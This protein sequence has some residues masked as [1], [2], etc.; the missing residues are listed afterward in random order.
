MFVRRLGE[1]HELAIV[2]KENTEVVSFGDTYTVVDPVEM[3]REG[4]AFLAPVGNQLYSFGDGDG[5][6]V[7][8]GKGTGNG[9]VFPDEELY[10]YEWAKFPN[11]KFFVQGPKKTIY[12]SGNPNKPL[13]VYISEPASITNPRKD[14]PYSTEEHVI[15]ASSGRL[16]VVDIIGSN[17]DYITAL[18]SRGNQVVVH[19]NKGCHLLYAPTSD[20][21]ETGYRVEQAPAT[22]FSAAV[23]SQVV[24][25]ETGSM[26]FWLGH[27]GQIYKDESASR[28]AE[29]VKNYADPAQVSWKSKS[30]W[31]KELH[32]DL[33]ESFAAYDRQSGMYW[34]YVLAPEYLKYIENNVPSL[35]T[36]LNAKPSIPG[37]VTDLSTLASPFLV[38]ALDA[39]PELPGVVSGVDAT[40][41]IPGLVTGLDGISPPFLVTALDAQPEL[42][43]YI[44]NLE[45]L[46]QPSLVTNLNATPALPGLVTS[47][48]VLA[49]IPGLVSNLDATPQI[50]GLV[51]SLTAEKD[52]VLPG[53]VGSLDATPEIPGLV[54]SLDATAEI[55]GLVSNLDA[56]PELP[57][58]VSSLTAE[59]PQ[60][61]PAPDNL[62]VILP[63][64]LPPSTSAQPNWDP[65]SNA[66]GYRI[67]VDAD[68]GGTLFSSPDIDLTPDS[69][70]LNIDYLDSLQRYAFRV[71]ALGDGDSFSDSDWSGVV[72]YT[73]LD[74]IPGL[75]SDLDATPELP[76][77]AG[78]LDATPEL[79]GL[80]SDLKIPQVL[81]SPWLSVGNSDDEPNAISYG[82]GFDRVDKTDVNPGID[83]TDYDTRIQASKFVD[84]SNLLMDSIDFSSSIFGDAITADTQY[85]FR[86]RYENS[87]EGHT[88]SDWNVVNYFKPLT[89]L[90]TPENLTVSFN[91]NMGDTDIS[92]EFTAR[93]D[94]V[95]NATNY[96]SQASLN[97]NMS[98]PTEISGDSNI[99][100][101][102]GRTA[103]VTYYVRFKAQAGA[104]YEDSDWTDIVSYTTGAAGRLAMPESITTV[105]PAGYDSN[106]EALAMWSPVEGARGYQFLVNDD[107]GG[108]RESD[109]PP[110]QFKLINMA[111]PPETT[112]FDLRDVTGDPN[113]YKYSLLP[114]EDYYLWVRALATPI[115]DEANSNM[116]HSY[117]L[118]P[119]NHRT[120]NTSALQQPGLVTNLSAEAEDT[121]LSCPVA[122]NFYWSWDG[123]KLVD[124]D[125]ADFDLNDTLFYTYVSYHKHAGTPWNGVHNG[126]GPF[127]NTLETAQSYVGTG[128]DDPNV[129]WG[130]N[131]TQKPWN[132]GKS[133]SWNHSLTGGPVYQMWQALRPGARDSE[134]MRKYYADFTGQGVPGNWNRN[135]KMRLERIGG[136]MK[137]VWSLGDVNLMTFNKVDNSD[138]C[139]MTG[140][141]VEQGEARYWIYVG[142]NPRSRGAD[143]MFADHSNG[144]EFELYT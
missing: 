94:E 26:S 53:L 98:D 79:P 105:I 107:S 68:N 87:T 75:V 31:E 136:V 22:N 14:S 124:N 125:G 103:G 18:S 15:D 25:G 138:P 44:T 82:Y 143:R 110:G 37:L 38:T 101:Y 42:P 28:G 9:G 20:Q 32:Y 1:V 141:Y 52:L 17:A 135:Y 81:N 2:S 85:Y 23:S 39:T 12:A 129:F 144:Q 13:R 16:S 118:G 72:Y 19:T 134:G 92:S 142:L 77:L 88:N 119:L 61:L 64:F 60:Q 86:V 73:T 51:S 59:P 113:D 27:D 33:S 80:V 104:G 62:R 121:G 34:I 128:V 133:V 71:K 10:S 78:N 65:V 126:G 108:D 139:Q 83:P 132:G 5:E 89:K 63:V 106:T 7:F 100:R 46:V 24:A 41:S 49:E 40:P 130:T 115:G 55:S 45:I 96:V 95:E 111:L 102:V 127:P 97:F 109:D 116:Q 11:C 6:A 29:D 137:L 21:A 70:L 50:P 76:G 93:V 54:N 140:K 122:D 58:L 131:P 57:G 69:T 114:G 84:F 120:T 90:D 66:I 123:T 43:G 35:V 4:K 112:Q 36:S 74:E 47:V 99:H 91:P 48:G 3:Y 67:Q 30:V 117:W 8:V 56:T